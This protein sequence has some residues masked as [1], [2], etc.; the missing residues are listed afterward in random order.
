MHPSALLLTG[1]VL[2][3]FGAQTAQ[4]Q[5]WP[6]VTRESKPWTRWWWHGSAVTEKDLTA[7]LQAY[8]QAGLGG[9]EITPIYGVAGHEENFIQYLSQSW[10]DRFTYTLGEA[11]RIGLGVDIATGTGWPFGGPWV[12]EEHAPKYV[13]HKSYRLSAGQRLAEPIAYQQEAIVRAVGNQ[14]YETHGIYRIPGRATQGTREQPA[15]RSGSRRID[16]EELVEPVATNPDLQTL[17]LDQVRF[18]KPLPLHVL[19]AYSDGGEVL[20]ITQHV[21]A[22]GKLDWAAPAGDWTLYALFQGWH[23]KMVE[24]AAPGGEGNVI[25]HFSRDALRQYLDHFDDSFAA[26]DIASLRAFFND[27][28]EVDDAAGEADWTPELFAEFESRRGYDLRQHLPALFGDDTR[29]LSDY[30][31]TISDLILERFTQQWRTWAEGKGALVRNQAHGSPANILDLYAASDIPETEGTQILRFKFA[32]SAANVTGKRFASAESA[33]WLGEHFTSSLAD[34]KKVLDAFML[35]GVNHIFYHGTA[36][37]PAEEPWPG[38]LFY[39]A[40]HFTPA[41]PWWTDFAALNHYVARTQ[42]FLQSGKPDNDV[43]LYYPVFDS[44]AVRGNALLQHFAGSPEADSSAFRTSAETMLERGY[45][46]DYISDRQLQNVEFANES[47]HTGDAQY[48]TVV[49]PEAHLLPLATLEKLLDLARAG[50]T[51]IVYRSMPVSVPGLGDLDARSARF[52]QLIESLRFAAVNNS[53]VREA[54]VGTG[55]FLLGDD[56]EQLLAH[57]QVRRETMVDPGLRF[58]RRKN[59]NATTYFVVNESDA[60]IDAWVPLQVSARSATLFDALSERSGYARLRAAGKER[61]EVYLQIPPGESRI[62][63]MLH[64]SVDGT[65]WSYLRT[66]G[67]AQ[68]IQGTW[69]LDFVEGGPELQ[70]GVQVQ[71]LGSW[72]ELGDSTLR[73]FSGTARYSISFGRPAHGERWVLDLGR[74]HES[75]RVR[76]NGRDLGTL[77]GPNFT[78]TVDSSQLGDEN[79]LEVSVTNLMANRIADL[80]RRGVFWKKF[81]NI[82]FPARLAENRGDNGLFDAAR[83]AP[84]PSGLIGPVTLTPVE[85]FQ[86]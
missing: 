16:I 1:C 24:R 50:A 5:E 56:L 37:S 77:I 42:S 10:M 75:A 80:D 67:Q 18:P 60:A 61:T 73:S 17:A 68:E 64:D 41:N 53:A 79:R 69:T 54:Q 81:Y 86:P 12:T 32:T 45:A 14:I 9:V 8:Q 43:L 33:T 57:A 13:A 44:F 71:E 11:Q 29:V 15:E 46:F 27:S 48:R 85:I 25:D 58:I 76:L 7:A 47:L 49:L 26:R 63:Q 74:V 22:D 21:A 82:N 4:G 51:V 66:A 40:V 34:V 84:R 59:Q 36:Y 20:D 31:E 2:L 30:R 38:W 83:W 28:Y 62:V 39:A 6:E 19:M 78:V 35:S 65:R 23:G 72:T 70:R 3:S 55:A 52:R